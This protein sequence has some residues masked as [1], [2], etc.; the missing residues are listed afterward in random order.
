MDG[1]HWVATVIT[2]SGIVTLMN[3]SY[4][5][6][7]C[8]ATVITASGIV[9]KGAGK[10]TFSSLVATAITASGIV[11]EY[12]L[13]LQFCISCNSDYCKRYCDFSIFICSSSFS[14]ARVIT[15]SGIV[16]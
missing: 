3:F 9:T 11:T 2:A 16:T 12:R 8:V 5:L 14:V 7:I 15:A 6:G 13:K 4:N 10:V 1:P